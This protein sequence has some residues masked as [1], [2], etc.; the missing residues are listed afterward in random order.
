MQPA[1]D[2]TW[3]SGGEH[4]AES[5]LRHCDEGRASTNA[6]SLE[7]VSAGFG[8]KSGHTGVCLKNILQILPQTESRGKLGVSYLVHHLDRNDMNCPFFLGQG[9]VRFFSHTADHE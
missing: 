1:P 7:L 3:N 8:A 2:P 4:R 6:S 9:C 5:E